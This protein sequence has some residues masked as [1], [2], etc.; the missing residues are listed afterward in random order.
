MPHFVGLFIMWVEMN[1]PY[2]IILSEAF[3]ELVPVYVAS[4][5]KASIDFGIDNKRRYS[6][7]LRYYEDTITRHAEDI[8]RNAVK[9]TS[10][11]MMQ[12][13]IRA[14]DTIDE[15]KLVYFLGL[16]ISTA[17]EEYELYTTSKINLF[18]MVC[19]LDH[20]LQ[21]L[22]AFRPKM[23]EAILDQIRRGKFS[24]KF[25]NTG[26]YLLYKCTGSAARE[27]QETS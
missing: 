13:K 5:G 1:K 20:R 18:S 19:M 17:L 8:I 7:L 16:S 15:Y 3:K 24:D 6:E 11:Y 22:N 14:V 4:F 12:F 10:Q 23:S 9:F 26:C 25:G 27:R 21:T 2:Q